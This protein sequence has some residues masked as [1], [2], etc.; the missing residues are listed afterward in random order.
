MAQLRLIAPVVRIDAYAAIAALGVLAATASCRASEAGP[1][2]GLVAPAGWRALPEI[3]G[4]ASEA[5]TQAGITVDG[6]DA[7]GD[8]AR[9]CYGAWLSLRGAGGAPDAIADRV[10]TELQAEPVLAGITVDRVVKPAGGADAGVL[11]LAFV[12]PPYRGTLRAQI[13]R[14]GSYALLA[15]F[16]NLREPIACE[17]ACAQLVGSMR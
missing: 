4:A 16:W 17:T 3:A 1:V 9:G 10:V 12:R 7:W 6:A 13:A 14:G 15:C 11:S 5:A 2:S 8:P